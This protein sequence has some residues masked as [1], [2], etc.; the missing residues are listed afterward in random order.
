VHEVD[1]RDALALLELRQ[2]YRAPGREAGVAAIE[3]GDDWDV[4]SEDGLA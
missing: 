2:A 1:D 3:P 4:L